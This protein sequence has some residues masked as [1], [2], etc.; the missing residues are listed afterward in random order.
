MNRI[1]QYLPDDELFS[2]DDLDEG[3]LFAF[4]GSRVDPG[5]GLQNNHQRHFDPTP[6]RW[7]SEEPT[8]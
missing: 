2:V 5:A 3:E 4:D 6:G 7:L 1:T 8:A